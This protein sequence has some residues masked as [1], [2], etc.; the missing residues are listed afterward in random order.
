ME[1]KIEEG[2][3]SVWARMLSPPLDSTNMNPTPPPM[4]PCEN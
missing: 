1:F 2:K 3:K 4:S